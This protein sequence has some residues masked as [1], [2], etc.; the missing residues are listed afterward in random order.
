PQA[1]QDVLI[2]SG[3]TVVFDAASQEVG[4]LRIAGIFQFSKTTSGTSLIVDGSLQIDSGGA[5]TAPARSAS[6]TELLHTMTIKKDLINNGTFDMRGGTGTTAGMNTCNAVNITFSG[7]SHANIHTGTYSSSNNE[8]NAITFN[9]TG[10]AA[11][12]LHGDVFTN[13]AGSVLPPNINFTEGI[14]YSGTN[15]FVVLSNGATVSSGSSNSYVLGKFGRSFSSAGGSKT[16]IVGDSSAYRPISV[17]TSSSGITSGHYLLAEVI[18]ANA[19]NGNSTFPDSVDAVSST[20]YFKTVYYQNTSSTPQLTFDYFTLSYGGD[21]GIIAGSSSI[22][23]AYSTD[24]RDVWLSAG[25]VS[26][27]AAIGTTPTSIQS[28]TLHTNLP[29][30]ANNGA[31]FLSIA[32]ATGGMGLSRP[33][34]IVAKIQGLFRAPGFADDT[35]EIEL[36]ESIS[37]YTSVYAKKILTENNAAVFTI[38]DMACNGQYYLVIRHR[39]AIET[40]SGTTVDFNSGKLE[41]NMSDSPSR[42]FGNNLVLLDS[43]WCLYSGDVNNDGIVDFSDLTLIDNAAFQFATGYL[44]EDVNGDGFVDF[45]DLTIVDNNAYIFAGVVSPQRQQAISSR[46]RIYSPSSAK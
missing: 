17:H 38:A 32:R 41:Y 33:V 22:R 28:S 29:V 25:P 43:A 37:P 20:R 10:G 13:T 31:L 30:L 23:T 5:C 21:D 44:P 34:S 4:G 42:A 7:T 26:H 18:H 11:V 16:F 1:G 14:V 40:W 45:S 39:N 19:N 8:F 9:K 15:K 46:K 2:A 6:G 3:D 27:I 35:L 12:Y 36:R 24:N